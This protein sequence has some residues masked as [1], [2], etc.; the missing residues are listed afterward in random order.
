MYPQSI[1]AD[2]LAEIATGR[3]LR[4]V[5]RDEGMPSI[6][7]VMVWLDEDEEFAQQYARA[8]LVRAD[9]KFDELDEVSQKA[10]DCESAVKVAGL[11][12]KADNIKWQL[13]RMNAKKYGDRT[14][15]EVNGDINLKHAFGLQ[16]E[17]ARFLEGLRGGS[18]DSGDAAPVPE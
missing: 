5:C 3:S 18:S 2:I 12:L 6:R 17:T 14:T 1:R 11:R 13:A 16:P 4:S 15:T 9:V 10:E 8:M 7:Q